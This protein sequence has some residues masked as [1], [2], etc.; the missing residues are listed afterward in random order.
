MLLLMSAAYRLACW[1]RWALQNKRDEK[2][3]AHED[4][5]RVLRASVVG[6]VGQN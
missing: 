1:A 6:I 3:S 5:A 2:Q 4:L